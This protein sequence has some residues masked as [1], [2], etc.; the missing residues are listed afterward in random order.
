MFE[1]SQL[2]LVDAVP[3]S[4]EQMVQV[5]NEVS[6]KKIVEFH[7]PF[8]IATTSGKPGEKVSLRDFQW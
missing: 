7:R 2:D 1:V 6:G 5:S 3:G 8:R 4:E